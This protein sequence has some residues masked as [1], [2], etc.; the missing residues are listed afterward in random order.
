[1]ESLRHGNVRCATYDGI[2]DDLLTAGLGKS[3]LAAQPPK[4]ADPLNP[5]AAELR[6]LAIYT[7]YR[8]IVDVSPGGGYGTL[9]GPNVLADATVTTDEGK[10]AG[11]E[12][13]SYADDGSGRKNVTLM[14]QIP[15]S[16]DSVSPCIV[17][18][19]SSGSRGI[20]GAIGTSGEWGL[21]NGCA[22][23]YTDKGTG[24]GAHDLQNDTV[25]LIDGVREGADIAGRRANFR[26]RI[27]DAERTAFNADTPGALLLNTPTP[28]RT[29]RPTGMSTC[30]RRPC[31]PSWGSTGG[32]QRRRSRRP[33][34]S[35]SAPACRMAARHRC[36]RRKSTGSG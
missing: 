4:I 2:S 34:P 22:V 13:L 14:V 15:E 33:A 32:F 16:F 28:S 5:T 12:C 8:A 10:I 17:T 27:S 24:T 30:C 35:S 25:N 23:A 31:L 36:A 7:N 21:K 20:Y 29:R 11:S 19:P 6:R 18:G 1:M 3:G 9:Y 26:A